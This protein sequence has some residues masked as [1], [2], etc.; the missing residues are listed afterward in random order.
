MVQ[1]KL[2]NT[3][4]VSGRPW[5]DEYWR[6]GDAHVNS[7]SELKERLRDAKF[8]FKSKARQ[9]RL[10]ELFLR[11]ER[12]LLSY[13][14]CELHE[15]QQ[16][17][18]QRQLHSGK[19]QGDA[20]G[21]LEAADEE[22]TFERLLDL[23][24]ELRNRIYS[25]YLESLGPLELPIPPPLTRVSRQLRRET[26]LLFFQS[27]TLY[28]LISG[29]GQLHL[30]E[31]VLEDIL[32]EYSMSDIATTFSRL[33]IEFLGNIRRLHVIGP[34][35]TSKDFWAYGE[36]IVELGVGDDGIRIS[37]GEAR[38]AHEHIDDGLQKFEEKMREIQDLL[39]TE[40]KGIMVREGNEKL[41]RGDFDLL[42]RTFESTYHKA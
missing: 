12:G 9:V 30:L 3:T 5:W 25:F 21:I 27:C 11:S 29:S 1:V 39:E 13:D 22:A 6:L 26:L 23:P 35:S 17:C 32:P 24:P 28:L 34:V 10:E 37:A 4:T 15:L 31:W 20:V 7:V 16:F 40:L 36:W 33:P 19:T 18:R 42:K 14:N 2:P 8:Y 38:C 41:Q